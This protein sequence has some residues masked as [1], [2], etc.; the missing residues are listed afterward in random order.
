MAKDSNQP[1]MSSI[2]EIESL[3]L[4]TESKNLIVQYNEEIGDRDGFIWK[5]LYNA[6]PLFRLDTVDDQ[7]TS[8]ARE[9]KL[10]FSIFVVVLD[11]VAELYSDK[12]TFEEARKIPFQSTIVDTTRESIDKE[13]IEYA[14]TVWESLQKTLEQAPQYNE[15][16][17]IFL[18][19]LRQT[20]NAL[21]YSWLI[22]D[23]PKMA[24][25][26]GCETYDPHNMGVFVYANIDLL[27]SPTF[28]QNDLATLRETIWDVQ[29]LG[30]VGNWVS[31]WE[32]EIFEEDYT[33]KVIIEAIR[34]DTVSV[35]ELENTNVSNEILRTRIQEKNI[36]EQILEEWEEIYNNRLDKEEQTE[37]VNLENYIRGMKPIRD[38]HLSSRGR[39]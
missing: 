23:I 10:I 3:E 26:T 37:S 8:T 14:Q 28:N 21:H 33:A 13:Y 6:S 17:E 19:D 12:A 35:D 34:N 20:I 11:D 39:K 5:W 22:N 29:Y 25:K 27:Y 30:R 15:Y 4:P 38:L 31:T 32:S 24:N 2:D 36:E 18:Y 7:H 16:Y 1:P 9:A